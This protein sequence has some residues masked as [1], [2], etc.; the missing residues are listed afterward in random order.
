M[1]WVRSTLT[2]RNSPG[3]ETGGS[4]EEGRFAVRR[5]ASGI[6]PGGSRPRRH[7][8]KGGAPAG[9]DGTEGTKVGRTEAV[10]L[11]PERKIDKSLN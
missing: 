2:L 4:T 6:K 11:G 3:Q 10:A 1:G 8:R 7:G 5:Q 9:R